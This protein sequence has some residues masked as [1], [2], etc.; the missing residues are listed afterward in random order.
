MYIKIK[1]GKQPIDY[2]KGQDILPPKYL[3]SEEQYDE[4]GMVAGMEQDFERLIE[5]KNNEIDFWKSE[6]EKYKQ[7]CI[8]NHLL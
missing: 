7:I 2:K 8:D 4:S 3:T 5:E 1:K 6:V